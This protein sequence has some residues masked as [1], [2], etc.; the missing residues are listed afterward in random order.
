[1]TKEQ[2]DR[3]DAVVTELADVRDE[4]LR[5]ARRIEVDLQKRI[6]EG[7]QP[8]AYLDEVMF[9]IRINERDAGRIDGAIYALNR[10][11]R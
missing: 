2:Q 3:I 6:A 10:A 9:S 8:Q 5:D 11:A 4:L 7:Q 1:M